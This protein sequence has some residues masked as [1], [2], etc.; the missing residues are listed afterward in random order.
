MNALHAIARVAR[1]KLRRRAT[2][3]WWAA[4]G[5]EIPLRLVAAIEEREL[6]ASFRNS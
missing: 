1:A 6:R 5:A 3:V 2:R 4:P